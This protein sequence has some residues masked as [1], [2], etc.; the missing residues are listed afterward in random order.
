MKIVCVIPARGGSKRLPRKNIHPL[1]GKPLICWSIDACLKS[2]YLNNDNIFVSTEDPEIKGLVESLGVNVIDRPEKLSQDEVWTQD[3]LSH[4]KNHIEAVG[5]DFDI[6][7]RV[8]ASSP[9]LQPEKIDECIEKLIDRNLWEVFTVNQDGIEDAAIHALLKKCIDQ[10]AL[11]VYKGV[12]STDYID[13]HTIDDIEL[14]K[15]KIPVEHDKSI[16]YESLKGKIIDISKN[17]SSKMTDFLQ[18]EKEKILESSLAGFPLIDGVSDSID[19]AFKH[20]MTSWHWNDKFSI[21]D[22][23]ETTLSDH[24]D[25]F[26]VL[27]KKISRGEKVK[28]LDLGSGFCLYWPILCEL[29][30]SEIVGIDLYDERA[31][32]QTC[33]TLRNSVIHVLNM[34]ESIKASIEPFPDTDA[35][36]L[37]RPV[38]EN[39]YKFLDK[40]WNVLFEIFSHNREYYWRT[41]HLLVDEFTSDDLSYRIFKGNISS[42]DIFLSPEDAG[43]FDGVMCINPGGPKKVIGTGVSSEVLDYISKKY[44]KEDGVTAF[45]RV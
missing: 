7:V 8:Q 16:D 39:L 40:Q 30:V 3:V 41:S 14:V 31:H 21:V 1:L 15:Q 2:K 9:Q 22:R 33:A 42:I 11:S 27:N 24:E 44:L 20:Y 32:P 10:E 18:N 26:T 25:F 45:D 29:G 38:I 13:I 43:S 12:V 28:I 17:L 5:L 37:Q 35:F 34:S 4:A 19:E 23:V 36:T 6:M